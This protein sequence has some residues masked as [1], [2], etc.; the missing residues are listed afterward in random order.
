MSVFPE[1]DMSCPS[2][3][4]TTKEEYPYDT[5][6]LV[7]CSKCGRKQWLRFASGLKNGW[8]K[9]CGGLTMPIIKTKANIRKAVQEGKEETRKNK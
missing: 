8:S 6:T 4:K 9:C 3:T 5:D 1:E 7:Q 2:Q